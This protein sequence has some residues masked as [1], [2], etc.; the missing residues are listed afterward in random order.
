MA[1]QDT[2]YSIIIDAVLTDKGREKMAKGTF[3]VTKF[4]FGDDEIDYALQESGSL[5][6]ELHTPV[7]ELTMPQISLTASAMYEA[8]AGKTSNIHYGLISYPNQNILYLPVLK[9]NTKELVSD[10]VKA[11]GGFAAGTPT[12]SIIYL[13]VNDETTNKVNSI[14]SGTLSF[15]QANSL[16]LSRIIIESG[17]DGLPE[18]PSE[19]VQEKMEP[20]E[21]KDEY[22]GVTT[23]ASEYF[24][25]RYG[26]IDYNYTVYADTRF[27]RKVVGIRGCDAKFKNHKN[28][29]VEINFVSSYDS[30]PTTIASSFDSHKAFVIEGVRNEMVDFT[31]LPDGHGSSRKFSS[32]H[33]PKGTIT[34]FNL[35]IDNDLKINSG[36]T[37]NYKYTNYGEI[38]KMVFDDTHKFDYID[39]TL[40]VVGYATMARIQV[41]IRIVRYAGK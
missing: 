22:F 38:D 40:E 13:T 32:L 41:P 30:S 39:T 14:L 35:D 34:A 29:A 37:R 36:G 12:G 7:T 2:S 28:S 20:D 3:E 23:A 18:Y 15:L 8:F 4:A 31:H 9:L 26:L 5:I 10:G 27:V 1:F 19:A 6:D 21:L 25:A 11:A 33:G 16:D 17:L 24:L